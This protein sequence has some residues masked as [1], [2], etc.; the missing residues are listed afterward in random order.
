MQGLDSS[1]RNRVKRSIIRRKQNSQIPSIPVSMNA[2]NEGRAQPCHSARATG[3]VKV[4]EWFGRPYCELS[5]RPTAVGSSPTG[6]TEGN[7]HGGCAEPRL[8]AWIAGEEAGRRALA[9]HPRKPGLTGWGRF[10]SAVVHLLL[11]HLSSLTAATRR[12]PGN[13]SGGRGFLKD[14]TQGSAERNA[15]MAEG[16]RDDEAG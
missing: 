12:Q 1:T 14:I 15:G 16:D 4:A 2:A 11:F 6:P 10:E 8:A 5:S 9:R 3:T 7:E 13:V